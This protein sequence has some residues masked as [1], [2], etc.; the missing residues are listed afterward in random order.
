[1]PTVTIGEN[2]ADDYGGNTIDNRIV[3]S[4][5]DTNY[6]SSDI[7]YFRSNAANRYNVLL[8]FPDVTSLPS[9]LTVSSSSV[10]MYL[11]SQFSTDTF[12]IQWR[13][14][15][16][17]RNWIEDESTWNNASTTPDLEWTTPGCLSDG[18]DRSATVSASGSIASTLSQY[19][20]HSGSQLNT[21]IEN[22]VESVTESYGYIGE[23]SDTS[24]SATSYKGMSSSE[25]TNTQRPYLSVTYTT[26]GGTDFTETIEESL[27]LSDSVSR[28]IGFS[29]SISESLGLTDTFLKIAAYSRLNSESLGLA[30][31]QTKEAEYNRTNTESLGLT[32]TQIK[33]TGFNRSFSESI[34][35]T[36]IATAVKIIAK[37]ISDSIGLTDTVS[38]V[39]GF[40]KTISD[41]IGLTD[42]FSRVASFFRTVSDSLGLTDTVDYPSPFVSEGPGAFILDDL[43]TFFNQDIGLNY[44][45]DLDTFLNMGEFA[46]SA[47]YTAAGEDAVV[48][49][50]IYDPEEIVIDPFTE[51]QTAIP[52]R[53]ITATSDVP[54]IRHKD[55]IVV[56]SVTY[57]VLKAFDNKGV[58]EITLKKT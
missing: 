20:A 23:R 26:G 52:P 31:T 51:E 39:A 3:A 41:A 29:K 6:G 42:V 15:D 13:K 56:D 17:D 36:D 46:M 47:Q 19:Y 22:D 1:M 32:D 4:S 44:I 10:N 9:G 37:T 12:T 58:T 8:S 5:V 48:I 50:V 24:S 57:G 16:D 28:S 30:D 7:L 40:S 11:K 34:G 43:E 35:L 25:D 27:G 14:I 33:E 53:V 54:N 49:E 45:N 55:V 2:T 18:N 38:K 21:D